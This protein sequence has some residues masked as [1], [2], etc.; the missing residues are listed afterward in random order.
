MTAVAL[1]RKM[2]EK[3]GFRIEYSK[4]ENEKIYVKE[5]NEYKEKVEEL[6]KAT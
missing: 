6:W 1:G 4:E 2:E 5:M 3:Y